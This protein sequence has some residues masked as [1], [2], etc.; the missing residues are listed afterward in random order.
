M[1]SINTKQRWVLFVTMGLLLLGYI[2]FTLFR[3]YNSAQAEGRKPY[4]PKIITSKAEP[5]LEKRISILAKRYKIYSK[6]YAVEYWLEGEVNP[7]GLDRFEYEI[8]V[9]VNREDVDKWLTYLSKVDTPLDISSK[10]LKLDSSEWMHNST[11]E[12]YISGV[13]VMMVYRNEGIIIINY[14][15]Y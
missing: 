11:P 14:N 8:A 1:I 2:I 3:L 6:V 15:T 9:K 7:Y 4:V 10:E 12:F 13:T 5:S